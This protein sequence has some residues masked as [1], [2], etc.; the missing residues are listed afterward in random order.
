MKLLFQRSFPTMFIFL[1]F[2]TV[3]FLQRNKKS[4][5]TLEIYLLKVN[6]EERSRKENQ[7]FC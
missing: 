2:I 5:S 4:I 7:F 1:K 3:I 6:D